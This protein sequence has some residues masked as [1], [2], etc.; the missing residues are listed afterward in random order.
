[1]DGRLKTEWHDLEAAP[2]DHRV[3]LR[4]VRMI[5]IR[6]EGL[7]TVHTPLRIEVTYS[8]LCGGRGVNMLAMIL[9]DVEDTC[10][11]NTGSGH[12]PLPPG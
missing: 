4:S 8:R 5:P 12:V 7:I 1:M 9:N 6:F 11:F 3:R 2:G 10:V